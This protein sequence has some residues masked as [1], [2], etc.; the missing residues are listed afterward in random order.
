[1]FDVYENHVMGT[2]QQGKGKSSRIKNKYYSYILE[3]P[4][5][6]YRGL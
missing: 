3:R 2:C 5:L 6:C 4:L 1:M